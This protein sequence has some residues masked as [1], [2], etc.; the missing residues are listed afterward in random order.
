MNE[1]YFKETIR[2]LYEYFRFKDAPLSQTLEQW[3]NKVKWIPDH[4]IPKIVDEIEKKDTLPRNIP[5]LII[6]TYKS[7]PG[8]PKK[9]DETEDPNY[10]MDYLW[11]ALDVLKK[12]GEEAFR[13]Y[14]EYV[15]MPANDIPRVLAKFRCAYTYSDVKK[16]NKEVIQAQENA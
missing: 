8:K 5:S 15:K 4:A 2:G 12:E 11:K 3:Y 14:C 13:K 9:Y 6:Y 1:T 16:V 7:L 10:P